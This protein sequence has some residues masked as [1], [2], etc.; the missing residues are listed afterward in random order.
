MSDIIEETTLEADF[1]GVSFPVSDCPFECGHDGAEHT[2]YGKD[3]ADCEPTG[4]QPYRGTLLIPFFNGVE[5]F[6]NTPL[7]PDTYLAFIDTISRNPIGQMTHPLLG[8]VRAFVRKW[9]V[10]PSADVRNG[11]EVQV[12]WTEHNASAQLFV[13]KSGQTPQDAS[14]AVS[15]QAAAADAAMATAAP[16][17]GYTPVAPIVDAQLVVVENPD[18]SPEDISTATR[19]MVEAC[20]NNLALAIFADASSTDAVLELE[21]TRSRA[22]DLRDSLLEGL[23]AANTFVTSFDMTV[24]EIAA[25]V[26]GDA[27][28]TEKLF[29][30][31]PVLRA[32][33]LFVPPGVSIIVPPLAA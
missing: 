13:G 7:F 16:G 11:V 18:S 21:R 26:Y 4:Q 22:Y 24:H 10:K 30:A 31:N 12:E 2:A 29:D 32:N 17:G 9:S 33:P 28:E 19:L 15:S 25:L 5:G 1:E 23:R 20:D 27:R 14:Q 6:E 8:A 3:G